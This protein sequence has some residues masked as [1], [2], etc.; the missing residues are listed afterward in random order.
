M[1][2]RYKCGGIEIFKCP[3]AEK[4]KTKYGE[5]TKKRSKNR[6]QRPNLVTKRKRSEH[7][8]D[9]P[10]ELSENPKI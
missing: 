7:H 3:N 9:N 6:V 8:S 5:Q 2:K 4:D 10:C 1:Q